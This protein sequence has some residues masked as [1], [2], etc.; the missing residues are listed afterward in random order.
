MMKTKIDK[1]MKISKEI[2][3]M[4]AALSRPSPCPS[5]PQEEDTMAVPFLALLCIQQI[6]AW[7]VLYY[8][9]LL[10]RMKR[11]ARLILGKKRMKKNRRNKRKRRKRKKKIL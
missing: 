4:A 3:T 9:G 5:P 8:H 11:V 2:S 7:R 10:L 6:S 1:L